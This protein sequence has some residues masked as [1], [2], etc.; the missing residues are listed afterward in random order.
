MDVEK[1]KEKMESAQKAVEDIKDPELKKIAF[2]NILNKLL[3]EERKVVRKKKGKK[4]SKLNRK[5]GSDAEIDKITEKII[6]SINRTEYPNMYKLSKGGDQSLYLLKI[7]RD[8]LNIDGL[9]P[10]QISKVLFEN[11]RIKLTSN[12]VSMALMQAKTH[13]DR[14]AISI[15]GG[16]GYRYYLMH[17]GEKYL[18][19][20]ISKLN[21]SES[22]NKT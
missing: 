3:V 6:S 17:S 9:I 2:E 18:D 7:A 19:N 5:S 11:F 1:L 16:R 10:S 13:V 20:L 12:A 8:K 22:K 15:R 4:G 21:V 14:K